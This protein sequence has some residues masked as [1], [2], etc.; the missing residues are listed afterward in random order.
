MNFTAPL[1]STIKAKTLIIHGDRD[2]FFPVNI[3][4]EMYN[5]IPDAY[6]WIVPNG[7]HVPIFDLGPEFIR[8]TMSFL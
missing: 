2:N 1:L 3:P 6:L 4:V 5:A 7:V 8:R